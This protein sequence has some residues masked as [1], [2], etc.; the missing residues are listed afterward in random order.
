M[1]ACQIIVPEGVYGQATFYSSIF[2]ALSSQHFIISKIV[3]LRYLNGHFMNT[4]DDRSG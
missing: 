2:L 4:M 1:I 3:Y